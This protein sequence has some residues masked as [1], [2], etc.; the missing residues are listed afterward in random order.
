M[1]HPDC[2]AARAP[3]DRA[4]LL[5]SVTLVLLSV[6]FALTPGLVADVAPS[7][8]VERYCHEYNSTGSDDDLCLTFCPIALLGLSVVAAALPEGRRIWSRAVLR[9]TKLAVFALAWSLELLM[10]GWIEVGSIP[11]TI[12]AGQNV[13]LVLWLIAFCLAPLGVGMTFLISLPD[14]LRRQPP[15]RTVGR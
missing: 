13:A 11:A 12:A 3:F 7:G 1:T 14:L 6:A 5:A 8:D 10:L 2:L 15:G 9:G 4:V